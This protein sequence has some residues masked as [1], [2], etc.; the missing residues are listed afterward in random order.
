MRA[1]IYT[2][3]GGVDVIDIQSVSIPKI[4]NDQVLIKILA[5]GLNRSDILQRL[6]FYPAPP[7]VPENI[8]GIEFVGI[9]EKLG[10][11]VTLFQKG[12]RV[13]GIAGGGTHAEYTVSHERLL[14]AVPDEIDTIQAAAIP[15]SFITAFDALFIRA[16]TMPGE[17]IL[18]HAAGGGVGTAVIQLANVSGCE[19]VGTSRSENKM[20]KIMEIGASSVINTS[21]GP[22]SE[23]VLEKTEGKGVHV[24]I[25]FLGGSYIEQNLKS[26][27]RDGRLILLG[28]MGGIESKIDLEYLLNKRIQ[29]I[30]SQ[31]RHRPI[32][33][34]ILIT[35]LFNQTIISQFSRG[36][37]RPIVD[38][39]FKLQDLAAAHKHMVS[40]DV[41]GKIVISME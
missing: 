14:I 32:E 34:K 1:A 37:I 24:C 41:F 36:L 7:D 17:K 30:T 26:L 4:N 25:D 19:V 11:A 40:N 38:S 8:P 31:L 3:K 27:G 15:E 28:L 39:V 16:K 12:Q 9:I 22:F 35:R 6:G 18:V 23:A 29:I 10:E 5:S 13:F 33:E 21:K 20:A 2:G